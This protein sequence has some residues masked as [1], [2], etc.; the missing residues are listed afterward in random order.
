MSSYVTLAQLRTAV[1]IDTASDTTDD[2]RLR[3]AAEQASSLVDE[4]LRRIRPGFVGFAGSSNTRGSAGS[5]TRYYDGTG[6]DTLFID[7]ADTVA[8]VTVDGTAVASTNWQTWPYNETPKRAILYKFP[9]S[10]VYGLTTSTW[11]EGTANVAV[12]GYFGLATV[13]ND[14]YE[15][16]MA[17]A[18]ILWRRQQK[19]DYAGS[20]MSLNS[21]RFNAGA[22]RQFQYVVDPEL[23]ACLSGLDAGWAVDGVWGG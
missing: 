11:D 17:L 19:G 18:I 13:P 6:T 5:N 4:Y 12:T 22:G 16:T 20:S 9:V 14:V 8:T 15:V 2:A 23:Q 1:G 7:D 10:S 3:T 21:Q